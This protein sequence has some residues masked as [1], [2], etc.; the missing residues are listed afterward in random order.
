MTYVQIIRTQDGHTRSFS[1]TGHTEYQTEGNDVVCAGVSAIVINTVNCLNDILKE[2]L[3][4]DYDEENGGDLVCNFPADLN[5]EGELL[6]DCMIHGLEW[7]EEQ[8]GKKYVNHTVIQ[9]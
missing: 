5:Q 7:I 3:E 1:C 6:I 4:V 2:Q 9:I 8:Y